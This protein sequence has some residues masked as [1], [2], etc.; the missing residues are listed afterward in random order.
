MCSTGK[1]QNSVRTPEECGTVLSPLSGDIHSLPA[2]YSSSRYE[3]QAGSIKVRPPPPPP[4]QC[5]G[6]VTWPTCHHSFSPCLPPRVY[7][8]RSRPSPVAKSRGEPGATGSCGY[9]FVKKPIGE[10][11]AN[12]LRGKNTGQRKSLGHLRRRSSLPFPRFCYRRNDFLSS[13]WLSVHY[14]RLRKNN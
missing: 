12:T 5:W 10:K 3:T 8:D 6:Q 7:W 1:Q 2:L 9:S 11:E 13:S 14:D 4:G